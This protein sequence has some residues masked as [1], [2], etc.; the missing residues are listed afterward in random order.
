MTLKRAMMAHDGNFS[1]PKSLKP[2]TMMVQMTWACL[3]LTLITVVS[4][5]F[6]I[7]LI[8]CT[9]YI[10]PICHAADTSFHGDHGLGDQAKCSM[11]RAS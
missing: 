2:E 5:F 3:P 4:I 11:L 9:S 8:S 10:T 7:P 6:S 1:N